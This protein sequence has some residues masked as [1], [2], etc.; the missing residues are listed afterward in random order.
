[1]PFIKGKHLQTGVG[2]AEGFLLQGACGARVLGLALGPLRIGM[3]QYVA[4]GAPADGVSPR[5]KPYGDAPG[6]PAVGDA[7]MEI[8]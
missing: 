1:M 4:Q 3:P 8:L 7:Q 6:P 2:G 5:Q